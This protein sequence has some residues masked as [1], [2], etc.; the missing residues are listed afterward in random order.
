MMAQFVLSELQKEHHR[1]VLDLDSPEA[2]RSRVK[3]KV[4]AYNGFTLHLSKMFADCVPRAGESCND[5]RIRVWKE[6]AESWRQLKNNEDDLIVATCLWTFVELILICC[7]CCCRCCC[8]CNC[9]S[10]SFVSS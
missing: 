9:Y 4:N 3:A 1:Y 6:A 8:C 10:S 7:C 2:S 5:T